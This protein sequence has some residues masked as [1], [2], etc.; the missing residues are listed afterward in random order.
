VCRLAT[1]R[2]R[3]RRPNGR[4]RWGA[5]LLA[6]RVRPPRRV[7]WLWCPQ[8]ALGA[9]MHACVVCSAA[10]TCGAADA[11]RAR[12]ASATPAHTS[13]QRRAG[14]LRAP[15]AW[16]RAASASR[17]RHALAM[18]S[19]TFCMCRTPLRVSAC[20]TS[21]PRPPSTVPV[22]H[23]SRTH[24]LPRLRTHARRR[25]GVLPLQPQG[26]AGR[27]ARLADLLV[28]RHCLRVCQAGVHVC[29]CV[30]H[31]HAC[32]C[33]SGSLGSAWRRQ[34]RAHTAVWFAAGQRACAVL[35]RHAC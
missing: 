20:P 19:C 34:L 32:R 35:A 6:A 4:Q 33:V 5:W 29:V 8:H 13:A 17:A 25:L 22:L 10:D 7:R 31:D 26:R 15:A 27:A 18:R 2:A 12:R 28:R 24:P 9:V 21:C 16:R 1:P 3:A 14:V 30:V 23:P 11:R